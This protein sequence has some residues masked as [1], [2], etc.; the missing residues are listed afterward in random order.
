MSTK[1]LCP[2]PIRY[3]PVYIV[4]NRIQVQKANSPTK[5][6]SSEIVE[7]RTDNPNFEKK[8]MKQQR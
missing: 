6:K 5:R 1:I 2:I 4:D 7:A 8:K 3:Y